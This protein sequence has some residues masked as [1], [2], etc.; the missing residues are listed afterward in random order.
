MGWAARPFY[1][2]LFWGL[3][4]LKGV[5]ADYE[6]IGSCCPSDRQCT[7]L[8]SLLPQRL[9]PGE[10]VLLEKVSVHSGEIDLSFAPISGM[11]FFNRSG[12]YKIIWKGEARSLSN[13]PWTLGFSLDNTIILGSVYGNYCRHSIFQKIAGSVVLSINAGQS[14]Q[15]VN[16][17]S[18]PVEFIPELSDPQDPLPS[19]SLC[20]SRFETIYPNLIEEPF[21]Y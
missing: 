8:F 13:T 19:F 12:I 7:K 16:A 1:L 6:F 15:F 3:I 11:I 5:Q 18:N 4:L 20:L 9:L 21:G 17:S 2:F 14:L 10:A